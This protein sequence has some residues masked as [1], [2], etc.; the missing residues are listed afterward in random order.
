MDGNEEAEIEHLTTLSEKIG[1][2]LRTAKCKKMP[3]CILFS[4][5]WWKPSNIQSL[6]HSLIKAR[7][8]PFSAQRYKQLSTRLACLW[9]FLGTCFLV[10]LFSRDS[11]SNIHTLPRKSATSPL[12]SKNLSGIL[13]QVNYWDFWTWFYIIQAP[14]F[15]CDRLLVQSFMEVCS[16]A[17]NQDPRRLSKRVTPP[18]GWWNLDASLCR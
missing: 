15:I 8:Q 2:Q 1:H 14:C 5:L 6:Q 12:F 17:S 11:N 3:T 10:Q 4:T 9:I 7:E 13:K 16:W 18:W